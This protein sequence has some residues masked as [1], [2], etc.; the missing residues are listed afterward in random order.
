MD[1]R[2]WILVVLMSFIPIIIVDLFKLLKIN[3]TRDEKN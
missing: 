1:T 2:H 3:G